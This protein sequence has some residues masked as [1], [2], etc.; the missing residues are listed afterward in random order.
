MRLHVFWEMKSYNGFFG[1]FIDKN[2][3]NKIDFHFIV[4]LIVLLKVAK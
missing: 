4:I 2:Q 1:A 3:K